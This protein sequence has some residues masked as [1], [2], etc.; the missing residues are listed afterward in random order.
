MCVREGSCVGYSAR[1]EGYS[2]ALKES[3]H[4]NRFRF[5]DGDGIC[6]DGGNGEEDSE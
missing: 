6:K 4:R 5:G 2:G 1:G 3:R